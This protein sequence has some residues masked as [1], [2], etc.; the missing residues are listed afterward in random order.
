MVFCY[1]SQAFAARYDLRDA[2]VAICAAAFRNNFASD[3]RKAANESVKSTLQ[4]LV[5]RGGVYLF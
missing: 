4:L 3:P 1:Y 5:D 2:T